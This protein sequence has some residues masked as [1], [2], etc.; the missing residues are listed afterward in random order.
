MAADAY[1]SPLPDIAGAQVLVRALNLLLYLREQESPVSAADL[2]AALG[3]PPSNIYRLVQT[4]ELAGLVERRGRGEIVLGLRLL[5]LGRVVQQRIDDEIVPVAQPV[6]RRLT[7]L[8]GETSLL[9]VRTGLQV[10]CVLSIDSPQPIRLSFAPGRVVPLTRGASGKVL[11]PWLPERIR[12]QV[13]EDARE[14]PSHQGDTLPPDVVER[15]LAPIRAQGYCITTGEVD[16]DTTAVA[17]PIL[18]EGGRLLGGLTVA[19]PSAR[20]PA[21]RLP[22]M[23]ERVI[24]AAVAIARRW[25]ATTRAAA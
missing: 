3:M 11:L 23:T 19:G 8:T 13:L 7:Q 2:V 18:V 9:T 12:R 16:P 6:M 20:L 4:L 24:D 15:E 5:D 25:D 22:Q 14:R 21:R 17:A 10:I 1:P